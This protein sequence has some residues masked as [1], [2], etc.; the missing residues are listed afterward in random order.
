M[1]TPRPSPPPCSPTA[2]TLVELMVVLVIIA[3]LSSLTLM[4][5]AGVRGRGKVAKTKSTIRKLDDC[6]SEILASYVDRRTQVDQ[7]ASSV[8]Y[9]CYR[10]AAGFHG[11]KL[12]QQNWPAPVTNERAV[13]LAFARTRLYQARQCQIFEMPDCWDDVPNVNPKNPIPVDAIPLHARRDI[14]AAFS[15]KGTALQK[16]ADEKSEK[17]G[18][19]HGPAECLFMIVASSLYGASELEHFRSDEVADTDGDGAPEFIDSWGNPLLFL[20]WAPGFVSM[21]QPAVA[22]PPL[23]ADRDPLDPLGVD[24][25]TRRLYPLIVSGGPDRFTGLRIPQEG[26]H[27][28]DITRL[29]TL[30][31][32]AGGQ[33]IPFGAPADPS[34]VLDN[35]TNHDLAR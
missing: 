1:A 11:P 24:P 13:Q 14:I 29:G 10:D 35:I 16:L 3:M 2:F 25:T 26:W 7:A 31:D 18:R 32:N 17:I 9:A 23:P 27:A 12:P 34:V 22:G 15:S 20:R 33:V 5:L 8:W 19:E 6:V 30:G 21:R 28:L 4:G